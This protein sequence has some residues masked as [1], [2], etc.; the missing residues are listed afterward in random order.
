MTRH[1]S[2]A[3][4]SARAEPRRVS[5]VDF[6]TDGSLPRTLDELSRASGARLTLR[7]TDRHR[8]V[9]TEDERRWA[10]VDEAPAAGALEIPLVVAGQRAGSILAEGLVAD[11]PIARAVADLARTAVEFCQQQLELEHRVS[12]LSA[13]FRLTGLLARA[14]DVGRVLELALDTALSTL[15]LDAGSIV[16]FEPDADGI[17]ASDREADLV[18]RASRNLS[19]GWLRSPEPLSRDRLFDRLALG[20]EIVVSEDLRRD[21]RILDPRRAEEEGLRACIN[22]GLVIAGRPIGVAR[23]YSRTPRV[24][25]E[26]EKRLVRSIA[27]QAAVAVEQ[28]R[29]LEI[30]RHERQVQRQLAMAADI[31]RRMMPRK[32]PS[33]PNVD[34]AGQSRPSLELGGDFYDVFEIGS[35][36]GIAV[37]DA[38]GKGIPAALLVASTRATLR[39][40]HDDEESPASMLHRVNVALARDAEPGEFVTVLCMALDPSTLELVA[41]T[42]GHDP[43]LLARVGEDGRYSIGELAV[44]GLVAGV[45]AREVYSDVRATLR[46]GDVL[47]VYT[48]GV[49]DTLDFHQA[50]F[51]KARLREAV[52]AHLREHPDA[53]AAG[54]LE[55][56]FWSLRQHAGLA[57]QAD[58]QTVVVAR[59]G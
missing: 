28:A 11:D 41:S 3:R 48:D 53:D 34:I 55:H 18:L 37:G 22:A 27:Q 25:R 21:D 7:D 20:G 52:L 1:A 39:A 36:I 32:V 19:E 38:V 59:I 12:E 26:E 15:E 40:H 44:T 23:L 46:P 56:V 4:R 47:V 6:M 8:I 42:A 54:V 24:F 17:A 13:L 33:R 9:A 16:L 31:Q 10:I 45:D 2:D 30:K 29:L 50:R 5:I 43:P 14:A 58:D 57:V 35:R 51:T 49:P